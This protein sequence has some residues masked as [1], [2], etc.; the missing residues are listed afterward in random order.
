MEGKA[1]IAIRWSICIQLLKACS[2]SMQFSVFV[3][4][5]AGRKNQSDEA[6]SV[7]M[8]DK[9]P[10]SVNIGHSR[11]KAFLLF[12]GSY[13]LM[14]CLRYDPTSTHEYGRSSNITHMV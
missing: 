5:T 7:V 8:W 2:E 13:K 6:E 10:Y 3:R 9:S 14:L 12:Q 1:Y 4:R 11:M